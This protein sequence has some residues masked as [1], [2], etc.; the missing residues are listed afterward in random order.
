MNTKAIIE[1]EVPNLNVFEVRG[2]VPLPDGYTFDSKSRECPF[3][4]V[5]PDGTELS[6]QWNLVTRTPD[7]FVA[8]AQ[9]MARCD[10]N[11]LP[12]GSRQQFKVIEKSQVSSWKSP[13]QDV[14]DLIFT[15]NKMRLRARDVFGNVYEESIHIGPGVGD[16]RILGI[17]SVRNVVEVCRPLIPK[18]SPTNAMVHLGAF[19]CVIIGRDD[20]T[21]VLELTL[22]YHNGLVPSPVSDIYFQELELVV[23][24]NWNAISEW[25]EPL[26]G[27]AYEEGSEK[28]I[29]LVKPN[30]DGTMHLMIQKDNRDW[31]L[32]IHKDGKSQE[33]QE[34]A[35]HKSWGVTRDGEEN[36]ERYWT[37]QNP[38]TANYQAQRAVMPSLA[39]VSNL[40]SKVRG[41]KNTIYSELANGQAYSS[42]GGGEGQLGYRNP[43][44][45]PYGGMTGGVEINEFEG[46]KALS[47]GIPEGLLFHRALSRRY[48]DRQRGGYIYELSGKPIELDDYLNPDGTPPWRMFN[49]TFQA[50]NWPNQ[51]LDDDEPFDFDMS[52]Q[53]QVNYVQSNSLTPSYENRTRAHDPIDDQHFVRRAKDLRTMIWLDN[54]Y[55]SKR[56][57]LMHCETLRMTYGENPGGRFHSKLGTALSRPH[58]GGGWGR[59]EAHVVDACC[60]GFAIA[61]DDWRSRWTDWFNTVADLVVTL[62][63]DNGVWDRHFSG[64]AITAFQFNGM[65]STQRPNEHQLMLHAIRGLHGSVFKNRDIVRASAVRVAGITGLIGVW[66]FLWKWQ[67]DGSGP[68]GGGWWDTVALGSLAPATPMW[69]RHFQHPP[70]QY[71]VPEDSYH[72]ANVLGYGMEQY[73][74]TPIEPTMRK[75]VETHLGTPNLLNELE[76]DGLD[77]LTSRA[78]L[79]AV[80]Q[81]LGG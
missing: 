61:D 44:G 35:E 45:V 31:R 50:Q 60:A 3:T 69:N 73:A 33:A 36:G 34:L 63:G 68:A 62:Q 16:V 7:G 79:L 81:E 8:V 1:C 57:L 58:T 38:A 46:V 10:R 11:G 64:K 47:A 66:I 74:G 24:A 12:V 76:S 75:V 77:R 39:H 41:D 52:D 70:E 4:L 6:T 5:A 22:S 80:L 14:K 54:D 53:T 13:S 48:G 56:H 21:D 2:N 42:G 32:Y 19:Q 78:H 71:V 25:P 72:V 30:A 17:G 20:E 65:Y 37:W 28:V 55:A 59:A 49:S 27:S 43:A 67:P 51:H 26:M 40:E 15:E 29:P 18:G 23:P 9:L